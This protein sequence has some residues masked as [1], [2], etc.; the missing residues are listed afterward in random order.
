MSQVNKTVKQIEEQKCSHFGN[1]ANEGMPGVH[2]ER[3]HSDS[4]G[5]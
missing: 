3:A 4:G 2:S 5:L 1:S